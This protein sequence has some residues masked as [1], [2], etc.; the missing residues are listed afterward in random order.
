MEEAYDSREGRVELADKLG[1]RVERLALLS[2]RF[3][4]D[5]HVEDWGFAQF[6]DLVDVRLQA[7]VSDQ[8]LAASEAILTN[9]LEARVAETDYDEATEGGRRYTAGISLDDVRIDSQIV[10]FFRAFGSTLDCLAGV[11]IGVLRVPRSVV[12]ASMNR[13]L[14]GLDPDKAPDE[15][16]KNAW[17]LFRASLD[18][19]REGPPAKWM[20]WALLYRNAAVHRPRQLNM[21]LPRPP[22]TSL[23]LPE[24]IALK[25]LRFDMYLRRR[26]W[27]PDL[28]HLAADEPVEDLFLHEPAPTT[29]RG[30]IEML[31]HSVE[32]LAHELLQAWDAVGSGKLVLPAATWLLDAEPDIDF[33]GFVPGRP[34]EFDMIR[35]HPQTAIRLVLAERLRRE[36]TRS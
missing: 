3:N 36:H 35:G 25:L 17:F 2:A 1:L 4:K 13:D 8:V 19:L 32:T 7:I 18:A 33:G 23:I 16:T 5:F 12:R 26:P 10:E 24:A 11:A 31:N 9:L 15:A 21:M 29:M 6:A 27:L 14:F 20:D 30:L 34:A 22:K 28:E